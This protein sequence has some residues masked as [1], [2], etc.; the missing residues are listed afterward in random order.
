MTKKKAIFVSTNEGLGDQ[1]V[2]QGGVRYL[3]FIY[4]K[5]Y[6]FCW[7]DFN[8]TSYIEHAKF[9]FKHDN[10][11]EIASIEKPNNFRD[12]LEKQ[13]LAKLKLIKQCYDET[14]NKNSD[15]EFEPYKRHFW[16]TVEEM[17]M[18]AENQ[19]HPVEQDKIIFP[20]IFYKVIEAP[21]Q[22][23]YQ[24]KKIHRNHKR[25]KEIFDMLNIQGPYAFCVNQGSGCKWNFKYDTTLPCVNPSNYP[26]LKNTLLFDWQLV[27]ERAS[28]IHMVDTSWLHLCRSLQLDIPKFFYSVKKFVTAEVNKKGEYIDEF[29]N[30]SY[31]NNWKKIE[32]KQCVKTRAK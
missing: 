1:I 30:D 19:E 12:R 2:I 24:L 16:P 9:L 29:L 3:S 4:D 17:L 31:D 20:R 13:K 15:Y 7:K 6:F 10:N 26:F 14:V 22:T 32:K 23:R 28:E 18:I 27:I 5:V 8:Q 11:I 25:E 21:Y